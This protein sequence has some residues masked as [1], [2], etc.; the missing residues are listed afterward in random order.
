[1]EIK[2]HDVVVCIMMVLGGAL[3]IMLVLNAVVTDEIPYMMCG[4]DGT[5]YEINKVMEK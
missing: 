2:L 5:M 4:S 1:M 3:I